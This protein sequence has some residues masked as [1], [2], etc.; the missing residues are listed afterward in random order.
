MGVGSTNVAPCKARRSYRYTAGASSD[1]RKNGDRVRALRVS[2]TISAP[3]RFASIAAAAAAR[4]G[5]PDEGATWPTIAR[6]RAACA[7]L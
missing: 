5:K 6:R 1:N 4:E 3:P 2:V 7:P